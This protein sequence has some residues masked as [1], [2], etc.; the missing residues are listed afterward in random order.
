MDEWVRVG[1]AVKRGLHKSRQQ[2]THW[3][4]RWREVT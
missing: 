2:V 4:M 1:D 3:I